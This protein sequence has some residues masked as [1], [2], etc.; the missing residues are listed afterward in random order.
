MYSIEN[1]TYKDFFKSIVTITV[2]TTILFTRTKETIRKTW[3]HFFVHLVQT[4]YTHP[5]GWK[6]ACIKLGE[7]KNVLSRGVFAIRLFE[8]YT[9][10]SVT[11][12]ATNPLRRLKKRRSEVLHGGKSPRKLLGLGTRVV[13]TGARLIQIIAR[14]ATPSKGVSK[15]PL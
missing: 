9:E 3:P 5:A 15:K 8:R 7:W 4:P 10:Y 1:N 12:L 13:L 14:A 6:D 11:T 2:S